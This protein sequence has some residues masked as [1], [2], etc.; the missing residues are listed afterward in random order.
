MSYAV[1]QRTREV[2]IRMA[3]GAERREV[4]RMV[5]GEGMA[6]A[7]LGVGL[8]LAAAFA[9]DAGLASL[10]S[11]PLTTMHS[12]MDLFPGCCLPWRWLHASSLPA[13]LSGR[14]HCGSAQ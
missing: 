5:I 10:L 11:E 14:T 9:V 4:L 2:G 13:G 12:L 1:A 6:L 8:G 3:L 7:L